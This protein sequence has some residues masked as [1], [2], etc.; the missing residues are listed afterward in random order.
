MIVNHDDRV[1]KLQQL[2]LREVI[3]I[4]KDGDGVTIQ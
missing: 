4:I 3:V 1:K 2:V